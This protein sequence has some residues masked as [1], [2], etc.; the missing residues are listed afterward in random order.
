MGRRFERLKIVNGTGIASVSADP[1]PILGGQ[2]GVGEYDIKFDSLL[3]ADEKYSGS[4]FDGILGTTLAFGDLVY[5]NKTDDRW[6]KTDADA[7][8]TA[9]NVMLAIVLAAGGDG[10]TRLLLS[11]GFV[12]EDDW[13]FA[14]SGEPVFVSLTTGEM[15][16]DVSAYTTGDIVRVIGY[17]STIADQIHFNPSNVWFEI[18]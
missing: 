18:A 15:T 4:T 9:G 14:E 16:Q 5:L 8:A 2:L 10:D 11:L 13:N 7:E 6:E 12:R 3:S 17:A 1:N